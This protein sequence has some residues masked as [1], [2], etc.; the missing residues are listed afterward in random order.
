M[1][2]AELLYILTFSIAQPSFHPKRPLKTQSYLYPQK[3]MRLEKLNWL[4]MKVC[5]A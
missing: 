5:W 2:A 1:D 3:K 4:P